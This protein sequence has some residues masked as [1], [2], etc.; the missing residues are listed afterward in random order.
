MKLEDYLKTLSEASFDDKKKE[1]LIDS[2]CPVYKLDTITV[3]VCKALQ[4]GDPLSG[5]DAYWESGGTYW[6][7]EFKNQDADKV[8]K[9]DICKKAYDSISTV[10]MAINQTITLD[11]LCNNSEFLV[12]YRDETPKGDV[13]TARKFAEFAGLDN[14]RA[15]LRKIQGKL[16]RK[17]HT[18]PKAEFCEKWIPRIWGEENNP[19]YL[20]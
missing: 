16:Y 19:S 12:V 10:R 13:E 20:E 8:K 2:D 18:M 1:T 9:A 6:F 7:I 14:I 5:C 17:V 3:Q 4:R 11:E 15:G